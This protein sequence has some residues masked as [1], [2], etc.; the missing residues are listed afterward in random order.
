MA[1]QNPGILAAIAALMTPDAAG[2]IAL[3]SSPPQF[4]NSKRIATM[5]AVRQL[6][7]Q[8]SSIIANSAASFTLGLAAIGATVISTVP[9][10]GTLNLPV[11]SSVPAGARIEILNFGTGTLSLAA[12]GGNGIIN[13]G[14]ASVPSYPLLA[15]DTVT[16]VSNGSNVWMAVDGAGQLKGSG[17]FGASLA[18]N[19]YQKFPSGAIFQWGTYSS[20]SSADVTLT[21]PLAFPNACLAIVT[22]TGYTPGGGVIGYSSASPISKTQAVARS[23]LSSQGCFYIAVGD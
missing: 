8:S 9:G 13:N 11:L 21:F 4:D 6:G 3:D 14:A 2:N 23:S 5:E 17:S 1:G 18:A 19:G 10:A 20:S 15:G 12:T 16:L 22:S 7:M